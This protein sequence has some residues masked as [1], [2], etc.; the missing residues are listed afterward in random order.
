MVQIQS[1]QERG[2]LANSMRNFIPDI[3]L[4]WGAYLFDLGFAGFFGIII[5]LQFVYFVIW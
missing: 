2:I 3:L 5:G 4:A 1:K